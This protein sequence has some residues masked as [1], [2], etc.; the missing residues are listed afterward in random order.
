MRNNRNDDY[1]PSYAKPSAR[2]APSRN[3]GAP[4]RPQ[5]KGSAPP[6][7]G[8]NAKPKVDTGMKNKVSLYPQFVTI[9]SFN[10]KGEGKSHI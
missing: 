2:P 10:I 4:S 5:K 9:C 1:S 3:K 7:P 6:K 8:A